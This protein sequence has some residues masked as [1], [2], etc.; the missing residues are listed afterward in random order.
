MLVQPA[1]TSHLF[2]RPVS[3]ADSTGLRGELQVLCGRL[4]CATV[5]A[6]AAATHSK[7]QPLVTGAPA[8]LGGRRSGLAVFG[9]DRVRDHLLQ[10]AF[11]VLVPDVL[12]FKHTV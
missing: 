4:R 10:L 8:R 1:L 5:Q 11:N 3:T 12:I 9:L 2:C 6:L 7:R